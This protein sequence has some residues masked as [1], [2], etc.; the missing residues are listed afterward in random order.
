MSKKE[1]E[2]QDLKNKDLKNLDLKKKDLKSNKVDPNSNTLKPRV[3][4]LALQGCIE[5]HI[6]ILQKLNVHTTKVFN[7]KDLHDIDKLILAGWR[8]HN[9]INAT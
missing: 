3:G 6:K 5:P 2:F 9:N 8:K 4:I 7:T 1:K